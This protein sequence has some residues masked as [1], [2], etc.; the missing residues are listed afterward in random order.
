MNRLIAYTAL[1]LTVFWFS[2][3]LVFAERI[4]IIWGEVDLEQRELILKIENN[5]SKPWTKYTLTAK[6]FD[7]SETPFLTSTVHVS[8]PLAAQG[9]AVI[10]FPLTKDLPQGKRFRVV[11]FLQSGSSKIAFNEWKNVTVFD[12][13]RRK[14][15]IGKIGEISEV[16]ALKNPIQMN[17]KKAMGVL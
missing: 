5:G 10:K 7:V 16:K 13:N 15:D 9:K 17:I 2:L 8:K 14:M 4:G 1:G 3:N 12:L 6:L 11:T